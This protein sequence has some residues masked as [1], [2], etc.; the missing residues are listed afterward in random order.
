MAMAS[1]TKGRKAKK[2]H[3]RSFPLQ[4]TLHLVDFLLLYLEVFFNPVCFAETSHVVAGH[5]A[6]V[7]PN[8]AARTQ[9]AGL[10]PTLTSAIITNSELNG[11]MLPPVRRK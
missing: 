10:S 8:V 4:K 1:P 5:A 9:M 6:S 7:F 3:K 2:A 11:T